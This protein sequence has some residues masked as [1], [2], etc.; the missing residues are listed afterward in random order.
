VRLGRATVLGTQ[1]VSPFDR[2][3]PRTSAGVRIAVGVWLLIGAGIACFDGYWW[4]LVI[5]LPAALHFYLA[6]RILKAR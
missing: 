2:R 1:L 4:G 6:Y 3:R 5:L